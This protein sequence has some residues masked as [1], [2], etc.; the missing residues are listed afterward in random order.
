MS[1][2]AEAPDIGQIL[3]SVRS[4][5]VIGF[6]D[7]VTRQSNGV[8]RYLA[9]A[10]YH[11]VGVNPTIAGRRVDDIKVYASLKAV[12]GPIDM[13]DVFR[14]PDHVEDVVREVVALREEK[15][16]KVLWLQLGL[17]NREAEAHAR[18]HGLTVVSDRCPKIELERRKA[19]L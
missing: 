1:A 7:D 2:A 16:F 5:A 6:S 3:T 19:A 12:P 13:V 10:G 14:R 15:S 11:V 9:R 8:A 17:S 18:A 4:I